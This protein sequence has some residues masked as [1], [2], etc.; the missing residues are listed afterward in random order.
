MGGIDFLMTIIYLPIFGLITFLGLSSVITFSYIARK[1]EAEK[2]KTTSTILTVFSAIVFSCAD[3]GFL[4][5]CQTIGFKQGPIF[6]F[7]LIGVQVII[8]IITVISFIKYK[9]NK[10]DNNM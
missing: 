1:K 9:K 7:L 4:S 2:V 5:L 10:K 3:I 8:S 6:V